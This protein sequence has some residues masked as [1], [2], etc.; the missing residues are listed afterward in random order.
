MNKLAIIL[1]RPPYGDINAA[2]AVRHALGAVGEEIEVSLLLLDSGILLAKENQ[3]DT[4]TGM[5]NLGA[6]LKDCIDMGVNV[7][8]DKTSLR[9][10]HVDEKDLIEGINIINSSELAEHIKEADKTVIF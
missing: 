6:A 1:R 8:A 4:G 7:Y 10:E 2:E 3:N 5:T 9:E